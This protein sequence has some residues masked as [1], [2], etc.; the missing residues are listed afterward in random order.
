VRNVGEFSVGGSIVKRFGNFSGEYLQGIF[1]RKCKGMSGNLGGG[2]SYS[3][4]VD[5]TKY[6]ME[7]MGW[8]MKQSK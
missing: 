5:E 1:R 7:K 4:M 2:I 8:I 6:T 3:L